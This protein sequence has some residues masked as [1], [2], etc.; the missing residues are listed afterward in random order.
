MYESFVLE[1]LLN[2]KSRVY[3]NHN[4]VPLKVRNEFIVE[5]KF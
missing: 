5:N 2:V 1:D 4:L 3:R